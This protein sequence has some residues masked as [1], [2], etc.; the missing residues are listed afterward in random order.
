[1]CEGLP[2]WLAAFQILGAVLFGVAYWMVR[3]L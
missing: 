1:M 3:K 2:L